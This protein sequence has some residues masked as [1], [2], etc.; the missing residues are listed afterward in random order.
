MT[1]EP[2]LRIV[3]LSLHTSPLA[4]AG[5]GDAGGLNVYVNAL[6]HALAGRSTATVDIITTDLDG[7]YENAA[8]PST[9]PGDCIRTLHP[10]LRIHV[11]RVWDSCQQDKSRLIECL[12][13]LADRAAVSLRRAGAAPVNLVHSHYWISGLAGL[14]LARQTGAPLVHTMH[15]IGAVKQERDPSAVEDPRRHPA[16]ERIAAAAAALTA[17]TRREA[18]DLQRHFGVDEERIAMVQP[19]TDLNTFYP[20][21]EQDPRH[22]PPGQRPFRLTFA[23]RLQPHK[24]PHVAVAAVGALRRLSPDLPVQLTVAGRQSGPDA[25]DISALAEAEG[26]T[27]VVE[28]KKPLPHPELAELFRTS[29]AVLVPSYSESF[30]LVALEAKACGTPVLAHNVGGLAELVDHGTT[31]MLINSLDPADWA[32]ALLRLAGDWERWK[33]YS[34][35]AVEL[36]QR[37]S[38]R[39][40]AAQAMV[41]YRRAQSM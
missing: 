40:T 4:Q 2:S 21:A 35:A 29:D 31:G 41:A 25:V 32:A 16:E 1:G 33:A 12:D 38:W 19:G 6:S 26:I 9:P 18:A 23:G 3:M 37:Y 34:T 28:L 5:T 17:N 8:G 7:Q 15:T 11:L 24:G 22:I 30:G 39:S 10:G 36:A 27:D 14:T 13:D 20:P